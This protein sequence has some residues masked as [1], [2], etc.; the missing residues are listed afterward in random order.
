MSD[1]LFDFEEPQRPEKTH[2]CTGMTCGVCHADARAKANEAIGRVYDHADP[3]W[4]AAA[5]ECL[6][7]RSRMNQ[8]FTTDEVMEDIAV[9]GVATHDP[10]A[11]GPVVKRFISKGVIVHTGEYVK[12]RRRHGSPIPVYVG[13]EAARRAEQQT[14]ENH[15]R[16]GSDSPSLDALPP[17]HPLADVYDGGDALDGGEL[18]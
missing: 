3:Q 15:D 13:V 11:L 2:A 18:W 5:G 6:W 4:L 1:G 12:S 17:R 10:R 8:H 16:R 7:R 14:S 9:M